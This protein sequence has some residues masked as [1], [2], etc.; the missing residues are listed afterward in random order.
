M[1]KKA[2]SETRVLITGASNGIGLATTKRLAALGYQVFATYRSI[3]RSGQLLALDT[4]M[5]NVHAIQLDVTDEEAVIAEKISHLGIDILINNAGIGLVGVAESF[6]IEQIEKV[7]EVNLIGAIKV[8]DAV[9]PGM[10]ARDSGKIITISS[11]VGPL[12]DMRQSIYS[13]TK[14]ALEHWSSGLLHDLQAHGFNIQVANVHPGPVVTHFETATPMGERFQGQDNPYGQMNEQ[15]TTW[16]ALMRQGRPVE[17]SV[18]TILRVIEAE[19]P[20]FWNPTE[21]RVRKNFAQVF[22]DPTGAEFIKGPQSSNT[23]PWFKEAI[24]EGTGRFNKPRGETVV[25]I[26]GAS[27]GIGLAAAKGFAEAGYHVIATARNPAASPELRAL[28]DSFPNLE[29]KSLDVTSSLQLLQKFVTEIGGYVD[30]LVN[31]AGIG[32][33]GPAESYTE[34]QVCTLLQTN[35]LGVIKMNFAV[36]PGMRERNVGMILSLSSIVGPIPSH[37]QPLYSA[38]KAM[39]E[40]F[41]AQLRN[42]LTDAGFDNIAIANIHPG[43][44]LTHFAIDIMQGTRFKTDNPYFLAAENNDRFIQAMKNGRSPEETV[45]TMLRLIHQPSCPFWNPTEPRVAENFARVYRDASGARFAQGPIFTFRKK[46][47]DSLADNKVIPVVGTDYLT[48][49]DDIMQLTQALY[50]GGSKVIEFVL[51]GSNARTVVNSSIFAQIKAIYPDMVIGVGTCVTPDDIQY[52]R[53]AGADFVVSANF[54][55]SCIEKADSEDIFYLPGVGDLG[56]FDA[57]ITGEERHPRSGKTV[58]EL[59]GGTGVATLKVHP[60]ASTDLIDVINATI[61]NDYQKQQGNIQFVDLEP[62]E[63]APKNWEITQVGQFSKK[64]H[65]SMLGG[66]YPYQ[67]RDDLGHWHNAIQEKDWSKISALTT[68]AMQLT[69]SQEKS[70]VNRIEET[71]ATQLAP[72]ARVSNHSIFTGNT[73]SDQAAQAAMTL[74][75]FPSV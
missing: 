46:I 1:L 14:I 8:T 47:H 38:S 60:G 33:L 73:D 57:L 9:L 64:P 13:A 29:V 51:R 58:H 25:V 24:P 61:M 62:S 22:Q 36:L 31:N 70:I 75:I 45:H 44:V 37:A 17:E 23:A 54:S 52:A 15:V 3:E 65:V 11:I 6:S 39:V 19:N 2:I 5:Q 34:E 48:C 35:V 74:P 4:D 7:I 72:T 68:Q 27:K 42:D 55:W 26:T 20:L 41:S 21:I 66:T 10:R 12:P 40:H 67:Y 63:L 56:R 30:I 43:A 69:H 18:D 59:L 53:E 50:K 71:Q 32:L 28:Q 49:F 16:R